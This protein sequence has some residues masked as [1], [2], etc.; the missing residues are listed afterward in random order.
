MKMQAALTGW[1]FRSPM[2]NALDTLIARMLAG[3]TAFRGTHRFPL[4]TYACS[5]VASIDGEPARSA[6]RRFLR[7]LA[8]FAYETAREAFENAGHHRNDLQIDENGGRRTGERL[9]LFMANGGLRA[10]W[11][12]LMPALCNQSPD[13]QFSWERGFRGLHPFWMLRYLS[14]NVHAVVA[15]ELSAKGEGFC[16]GGANAG[17]QAIASAIQSICC[18][19]IDVALVTAYDSLIEPE[20]LLDL[21][22]RGELFCG[23]PE[24]LRPPYDTGAKGF[25]PGEA[26]CTLVL[27]S[28]ENAGRRTLARLSAA[29][30]TEGFSHEPSEQALR[31]TILMVLDGDCIIDGAGRARP[32][33][34]GEEIQAC[35]ELL[36]PD[37]KLFSSSAYWG[38][39]GAA[40]SCMQAVLLSALLRRGV[41]PG[42][43]G[44]FNACNTRGHLDI[45]KENSSI[46]CRSALA[47][48]IGAPGAIGAVRVEVD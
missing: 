48:S 43:P 33:L 38:R 47:L 34:D 24:D 8:L 11:D 13:G 15:A 5:Y 10:D 6:H 37:A 21:G 9:G 45:L 16:F 1:A 22:V 40:T 32:A 41:L 29:H 42:L 44:L 23:S 4:D 36:A 26:A 17:A 25:V 2:G 46:G 31:R 35:S 19:C 14:N 20:L 18:N 28:L 7:R 12:E 39:L 27:E 30:T 3:E